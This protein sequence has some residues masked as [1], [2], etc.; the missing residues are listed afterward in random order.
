M[1]YHQKPKYSLDHLDLFETYKFGPIQKDEALFLFSL[2]KMTRPST[3]VEFGLLEGHSCLNFVCSKDEKTS[4]YGFDKDEN[5][6]ARAQ[7]FCEGRANCFL[8]QIDC[9]DFDSG[10]ID[11][12]TI[13]LCFLDCSHI[14]EVNQKC[15]EKVIPC[16]S[17]NAI[18]AIHDTGYYYKKNCNMLPKSFLDRK[19]AF[20]KRFESKDKVSAV[21]P[22]QH[23]VNWFKERW[24]DWQQLHMHSENIM[25]HGITLLQKYQKL[26]ID[27]G[28]N[29]R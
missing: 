27:G 17:E 19:P 1:I 13:D 6:V 15:L 8:S 25:R 22:E 11:G 10:K 5:A 26:M 29:D 18:L 16:M 3:I 9:I 12:R 20:L 23:T 21:K 14:L 28:Q 2:V 4:Y 7:K 24:P